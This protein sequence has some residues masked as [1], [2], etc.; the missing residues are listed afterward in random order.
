MQS[1][2]PSFPLIKVQKSRV[3]WLRLKLASCRGKVNNYQPLEHIQLLNLSDE[4]KEV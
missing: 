1:N 2:D 4:E 3:D